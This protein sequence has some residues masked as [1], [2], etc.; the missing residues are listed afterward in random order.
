MSEHDRWS[1]DLAAYALGALDPE[2][3]AE[4][5]RHAESCERCRSEIRW[6][7]PA[8]DALA[9]A[10]PRQAPPPA[11]RQR[12]MAEVRA[13]ARAAGVETASGGLRERLAGIRIGSLTWKPLAGLAAVVLVVAAIAGYE[14][15]NGGGGG[16]NASTYA[17]PP[18]S[19]IAA[20]VVSADG[21]GEIH[22]ADV[23]PLPE[24]RVLEAWVRRDGEVEAVKALFVPDREGNASTMLGSMRGVDLVMVTTEPAGGS[25]SPTGAPIAE[26]PIEQ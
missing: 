6:L 20:H 1:E 25:K 19:P 8:V 21:S 17:S 22:L 13:D 5:E 12:L 10:V 11:L 2:R 23:K 16:G 4:L 15:G 14:V 18:S 3:A 7:M 9:E 26:V 24:N